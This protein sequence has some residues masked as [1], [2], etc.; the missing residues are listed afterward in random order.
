MAFTVP[1]Y[2]TT[3]NAVA[4]QARSVASRHAK[5]IPATD[6]YQARR[7]ARVR[8]QL[9]RVDAMLLTE[10]DPQRLDR[11]A[12]ASMRLSDQEFALAN[13]PKPANARPTQSRPAARPEPLE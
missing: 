7:L 13:R 10:E 1:G 11:L 9:D 6:R 5:Q 8:E 2:F 4:M 3:A 12:A